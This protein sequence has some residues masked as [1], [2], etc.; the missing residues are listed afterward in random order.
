MSLSSSTLEEVAKNGGKVELAGAKADTLLLNSDDP[1][2]AVS[3]VSTW[4][5][6]ASGIICTVDGADDSPEEKV[7]IDAIKVAAKEACVSNSATMKVAVLP[8][9]MEI[10]NVEEEE[11]NNFFGSLLGGNKVVVP[12]SLKSAISSGVKGNTGILRYSM[13]NCLELLNHR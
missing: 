5:S 1:S 4:C 9:S 12:P 7:V 11:G 3:A 2:S 8:S 6:Q 13:E 10:E